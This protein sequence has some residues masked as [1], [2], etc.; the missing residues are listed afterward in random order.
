[1]IS[2][3][4]IDKRLSNVYIKDKN[5]I[6]NQNKKNRQITYVSFNKEALGLIKISLKNH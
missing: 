2:A 4:I 5:S 3:G 1:M 6:I